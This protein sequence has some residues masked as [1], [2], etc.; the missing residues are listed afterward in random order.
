[1][2]TAGKKSKIR[3]F[4]SYIDRDIDS[5]RRVKVDKTVDE[6]NPG[7]PYSSKL[8]RHK[9]EMKAMRGFDRR[10]WDRVVSGRRGAKNVA[11]Y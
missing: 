4:D 7:Q 9:K 3:V 8:L 11:G 5:T 2:I 10:Y 1:M 6:L